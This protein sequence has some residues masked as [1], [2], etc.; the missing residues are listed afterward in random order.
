MRKH[1]PATSHSRAEPAPNVPRGERHHA[2]GLNESVK[3][4]SRTRVV[5][6]CSTKILRKDTP[7]FPT[8]FNLLTQR[9]GT[10]LANNIDEHRATVFPGGWTHSIMPRDESSVH[11]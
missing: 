10:A 9:V 1:K 7:C 11:Q 6:T 3:K 4:K 5:P 8:Y 2:L